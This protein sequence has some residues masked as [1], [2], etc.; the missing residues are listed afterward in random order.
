MCTAVVGAGDPPAPASPTTRPTA[1]LIVER[2]KQNV[3]VP[4]NTATVDT[5]KAGDPD[6][7][8]TG[9]AT[10][11][12]DTLE[13][14]QK[15]AAAGCN[16]VIS[17]EPTFYNHLDRTEQFDGDAVLAEKRAFIAQHGMV[18]FRFHDHWHR[19]QPDGIDQGVVR[20]IGWE[21]FRKPG[22][23]RGLF[24]IPRTT[25]EDLARELKGKLGATVVRAVGKP[26][27]TFSKIGMLPGAAG[28][29]A[30]IKMLEREDVEVL[31][32][33]ETP[34]W[35]TVEYVRD[36]VTEGRPKALLL[37]GHAN[38]EEAGMEN[39]AEW[40]K[41]FVSEVPVKFIPAGDPFW[42]PKSAGIGPVQR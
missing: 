33:G 30:Q 26:E 34:E 38:S 41:G 28:S 39:C 11:H 18:V 17:H 9:I 19:R 32:I 5:F 4:W 8:V 22:E 12:L 10:T 2:I 37:L 7:A 35:E 14:L 3:G 23:T 1:R 15:A 29:A 25:L 27:A 16:L 24:E 20:K 21:K 6:T 40:L 31:L 42:E 13:V 36:A